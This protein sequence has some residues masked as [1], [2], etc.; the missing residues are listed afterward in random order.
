MPEET[1]LG[2]AG[3]VGDLA[4]AFRHCEALVRE[5]PRA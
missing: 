1:N 3:A 4:F 2:T 5:T